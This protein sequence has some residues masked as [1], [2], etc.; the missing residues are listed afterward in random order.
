[1]TE[2]KKWGAFETDPEAHW[3]K[4]RDLVGVTFQL[5]KVNKGFVKERPSY[6]FTL[7]EH[8][9]VSVGTDQTIGK[10]IDRAGLPPV[11]L[12]TVRKDTKKRDGSPMGGPKGYALVLDPVG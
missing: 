10:Q 8:R 12:Y 2:N 5:V 1:M 3:V 4:L 7:D 9:L 11:G 6:I